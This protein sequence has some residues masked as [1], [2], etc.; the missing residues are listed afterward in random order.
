VTGDPVDFFPSHAGNY[1]Q[2]Q[3]DFFPYCGIHRPVLLY[4]TPL[5][6]LRDVTVQAQLAG[7]H[8]R[9]HV[10]AE[11]ESSAAA[12]A[13][14]HLHGHGHHS[15]LETVFSGN[16][17]EAD[18]DVPG[19]ALWS[20]SS[21]NL[22]NLV[23]ELAQGEDA[24][25]S[26]SLKIGI[27][28]IRVEGNQLLLNDQPIYL[29][30]CGRHE[31]FPV[32]GRGYLPALI[33]KDYALMQW[34]GANSYRTS[35]YPYSEQMLDLAD[36]LGFLV[37]DET[38][39]VGL[40]FRE[41]GLEKRRALCQ[42]YVRE[43]VAR[44]K[45]HP[46]VIMWSLANEPHSISPNARPFF[47]QLYQ[48]TKTLDP[49][50]PV[51]LASFLGADE[52]AFEFC[53]L[54]CL[55]RYLGWYTQGGNL[56][57]ALSLLSAEL[58]ALHEKFGKPILLAEFGADAISGHHAQPPEMFSEEYQA[59]LLVRYIE[60]LRQKPYVIGEHI[61]NLCDFKTSQGITRVSAL[62]HK[63]VFTRDRRP[64]LAAQRIRALWCE[65]QA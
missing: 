25:D 61:W 34:I 29:K 47:E 4:A 50:R 11:S 23:V 53:E 18:I 26:Y 55:N 44:D 19:A 51:T 13:R 56:D 15:L 40:Y 62:N 41:D 27:R 3:F 32:V 1:P 21:P 45:N 20:P 43:I 59:E 63:G 46:S 5:D 10:R 58:D 65:T 60:L 42:Q 22:Y 36:Q 7:T 37:I 49:S 52:Q 14:I 30:G 38:P 28:T 12:I 24:I 2:A 54:V 9:I 39:A 64:K 48:E 16:L 33:V 57:E 8:G 35:H 31:D 6:A 17:A